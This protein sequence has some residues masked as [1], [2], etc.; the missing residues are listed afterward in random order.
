LNNRPR[1]TNVERQ[2]LNLNQIPLKKVYSLEHID[3]AISDF[4]GKVRN[5]NN[6]H[7][8]R[9]EEIIWRSITCNSESVTSRVYK[10]TAK[11]IRDYLDVNSLI[12]M[13]LEFTFI[14]KILFSR[15][16]LDVFKKFSDLKN[17]KEEK[18]NEIH[19][20][21]KCIYENYDDNNSA[22]NNNV[23]GEELVKEMDLY[24]AQF[25]IENYMK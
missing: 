17:L 10:E 21:L 3:A 12:K 2:S 5:M 15:T 20:N 22:R 24:A 11:K 16:M 23:I 14:K 1:K 8:P 25:F 13:M 7:Q 4:R 6:K 9:V 18:I 19:F